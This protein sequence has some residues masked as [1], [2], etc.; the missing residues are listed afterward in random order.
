MSRSDVGML[1]YGRE[2]WRELEFI[3]R[4][5]YSSSQ[6]FTD[7]VDAVLN[8]LLSLTDN[9]TK[10]DF[11]ERL[12]ENRLQGKFE[13][14]YME[15]VARYESNKEVGKRPADRFVKAWGLLQHETRETEKDVIGEIYQVMISRGEHGQYF[16]PHDLVDVMVEML[17]I[18]NQSTVSDPCCGSG[19]M[20]IS[21]AKRNPDGYFHGIDVSADCAKMAVINLWLF[22][23]NGEIYHGNTLSMKMKRAWIVRKG[24]WIYEKD[25]DV[26]PML[27]SAVQ[28]ETKAT[29][30]VQQKLF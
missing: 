23:M 2:V 20:L 12:R 29:A 4:E 27:P 10:P 8:S 9:S 11:L 22:E 19:R 26:E 7:F 17:G 24:G 18:A 30:P 13:D 5:G 28:E 1:W 25:C 15:V 21:A 16:T 3:T 6:V 14:R